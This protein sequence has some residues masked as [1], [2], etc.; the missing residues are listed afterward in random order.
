MNETMQELLGK[1]QDTALQ[2]GDTAADAAYGVG[3][4]AS[5]LLSEAKINV[6]LAGLRADVRTALQEA[7]ELIYATHTGQPTDSQ[8][9]LD[10]LEQIDEL[11]AQI[12]ELEGKLAEPLPV[13][14]TCGAKIRE[15]DL[16]CR[17][18]GGKL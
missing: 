11:N 10:K 1:V 3:K 17:E 9:L 16:F 8:I 12:A 2:L 4:R 7:G 15:E 13:C 14:P 5:R 6:K 18:C